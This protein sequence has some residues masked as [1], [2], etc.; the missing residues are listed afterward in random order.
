MQETWWV[1]E[2]DLDDDQKKIAA[3]P[4]KESHLITGPPG[5]GKTNLLLLRAK[6]YTLQKRENILVLVFT[7]AL[8]DFIV[9]GSTQYGLPSEIVLTSIGWSHA[10]LR[11]YGKDLNPSGN[12]AEQRKRLLQEVRA[13]VDSRSLKNIYEAI[14]LDEAQ[15][16]L[17]E[18]IELFRALAKELYASADPRQ[19][20][21]SGPDSLSIL[22]KSVN[23]VHPLR[24]HY[25]LG[26]EIC[27]VADAIFVGAQDEPLYNT[28]LYNEKLR[29]SSAEL[30]RCKTE[31]EQAS[32]IVKK[33][34]LQLA[35]YPEEL[36]GVVCPYT[37]QRDRLYN[38]IL[39]SE[40][41]ELAV[42]QSDEPVFEVEKPIYV[43]TLHSSKGL[44]YRANHLAFAESIRGWDYEKNMTYTAVTRTKTALSV[45]AIGQPPNDLAQAI[46]SLKPPPA[47]PSVKELFG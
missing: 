11:Q 13:F 1:A 34:K 4:A 32:Q 8:R 45:Y 10:F 27:R 39:K 5:C 7:R 19:K 29:P 9:S 36:L 42:N 26:H 31:D 20:I 15:D 24:Y 6:Y 12:F 14:F 44:E 25:R 47:P 3:L 41:G 17:P 16:Y 40:I 38:L 30:V 22:K 43:S 35:A 33:L 23:A 2:G 28:S 46:N 18:E 37:E 21:Y